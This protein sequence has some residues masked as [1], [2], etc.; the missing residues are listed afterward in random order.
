[1]P[2]VAIVLAAGSSTRFGANKLLGEFKGPLSICMLWTHWSLRPG[3]RDHRGGC[4]RSSKCGRPTAVPLRGE[5][6]HLEGMGFVAAGRRLCG[7]GKPRRILIALGDM[8]KIQ[9]RV[10]ECVARAFSTAGKTSY[11]PAIRGAGATPWS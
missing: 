10:G 7:A 9:Y 1:M 11:F 4:V 8:P 3:E 6:D 5:R 2:I